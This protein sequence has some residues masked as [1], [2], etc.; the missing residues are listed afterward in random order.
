MQANR[1]T[2]RPFN[3]LDPLIYGLRTLQK[4]WKPFIL[5]F[6]AL[7]TTYLFCIVICFIFLYVCIGHISFNLIFQNAVISFGSVR[8]APGILFL[9]NIGGLIPYAIV[10]AEFSAIAL[11]VYNNRPIILKN[12]F[13]SSLSYLMPII[14]TIVSYLIIYSCVPNF[15]NTLINTY[16]IKIPLFIL[17]EIANFLIYVLLSFYIFFIIEQKSTIIG[18]LKQS[19]QLTHKHLKL[20]MYSHLM[21]ILFWA[22]CILLSMISAGIILGPLY[23]I[24]S[25]LLLYNYI[26]NIVA[27]AIGSL[28]F[29]FIF[30][31][32]FS[33]PSLCKVYMYKKLLEYKYII[34]KEIA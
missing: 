1:P 11:N 31:M 21:I 15:F 29:F 25:H 17:I 3:Y 5:A 30:F 22:T 10:V 4:E 12:I 26:F 13:S 27:T 18:S 7:G 6:L 9:V 24:L 33:V 23:F 34:N 28:F 14:I 20:L 8:A 19:Y 16:Y 32:F 2:N